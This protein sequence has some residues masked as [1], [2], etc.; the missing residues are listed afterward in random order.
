L[1][2]P[3]VIIAPTKFVIPYCLCTIL[4][5]ISFGFLHGFYSYARHL[6]A[7]D[8]WVFSAAFLA[9]TVG[10]LYVAM[11]IKVYFLTVPMALI[12]LVAMGAYFVSYLPGGASGISM[13]GSMAT[14]SLRARFT[15]F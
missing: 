6:I 14:S 11:V 1:H 5:F 9:S 7:P 8:R 15:G 12:Q 2:L 10:T 4:V 13:F 3:L